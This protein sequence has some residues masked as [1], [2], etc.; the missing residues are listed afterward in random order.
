MFIVSYASYLLSAAMMFRPVWLVSWL[1]PRSLKYNYFDAG[2]FTLSTEILTQHH[3][4]NRV[5]SIEVEEEGAVAIITSRVARPA[6]GN[7]GVVVTVLCIPAE[8]PDGEGR[9]GEGCVRCK[10]RMFCL[11]LHSSRLYVSWFA[12]VG[13]LS[14][15]RN[16]LKGT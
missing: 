4:G 16:A 2:F 1:A 3:V 6:G 9:G 5:V 15:E 14:P 13:Y 7:N 8:R 11:P 10:P 12:V